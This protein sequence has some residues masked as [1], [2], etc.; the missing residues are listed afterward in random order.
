MEK[1]ASEIKL[2]LNGISHGDSEHSLKL[3]YIRYH[4]AMYRYLFVF[5]KSE[6]VAKELTSDVFIAIWENRK[7]LTEI[8][9]FNGYIYKIAKFKALNYLRD[10][11]LETMDVEDA[12]LDLFFQT[13][14]TPENEYISKETVSL[15][16]AAIEELPPKCKLV[17]KLIREDNMKYR[18][19]AEHLGVSIKT[20]ENHLAAAIKKMRARFL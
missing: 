20:V 8:E 19:V 12:N 1:H 17:F 15:I 7:Q 11:K 2:I 4:R 5:V 13:R 6:E 14:T 18:D 16:N 10:I 9:N 3:L